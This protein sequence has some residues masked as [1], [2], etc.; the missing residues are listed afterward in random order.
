MNAINGS[1]FINGNEVPLLEVVHHAN[2]KERI[3]VFENQTLGNIRE[4]GTLLRPGN[5]SKRLR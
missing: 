1:A 3:M 2:R 4:S 5:A